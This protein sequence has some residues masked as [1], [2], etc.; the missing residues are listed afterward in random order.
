MLCSYYYYERGKTLN[1]IKRI[2]NIDNT[3][4]NKLEKLQDVLKLHESKKSKNY[5]KLSHI[6]WSENLKKQRQASDYFILVVNNTK[7][8]N[9]I[10]VNP[11]L[12]I[13]KELNNKFHYVPLNH[14]MLM[15]I[16]ALVKN[17]SKP[18]YQDINSNRFLYSEHSG[19]LQLNKE[20]QISGILVSTD[21]NRSD[22]N[23]TD[24]LLPQ[25]SD[26]LAQSP[27][28]FHTH[29]NNSKYAG[30]VK[31]GVLYEFPSA[32]DV[33]NFMKYHDEGQAQASIV[34]APEGLY[35]IRSVCYQPQY[36]FNPHLFHSLRKFILLIETAAIRKHKN[37]LNQLHDPD[38][39]HQKIAN[40]YTYI[41]LYNRF[42]KPANLFIEYYPRIKR[43]NEWV[44]PSINLMLLIK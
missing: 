6:I 3:F 9:G 5:F 26:I 30:R 39:F 13:P 31:D 8:N 34:A 42:I 43:N 2:D 37:E 12:R 28:I 38:L 11:P 1:T 14:N 15:I 23:D 16:D 19:I 17:G 44:L 24:I 41:N 36:K 10:I 4:Y 21:S 27:Y 35:V 7:I 20:N 32:N 25:N 18:R 33:Y 29:P 22:L 40:D